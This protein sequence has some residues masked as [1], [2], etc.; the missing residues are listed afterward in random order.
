M[1]IAI[2][3]DD[4]DLLR[5]L[6]TVLGRDGG[7]VF[8][9]P[10][11]E[12]ALLMLR[13][14]LPLDVLIVDYQLGAF[15]AGWLLDRVRDSLPEGCRVILISGVS[16]LAERLDLRKMGVETFLPKPLDLRLLREK[17]AG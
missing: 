12:W 14:R 4:R 7:K 17:V 3:E 15:H 11:A 16:G 9:F 13:Q 2:V 1:R 8:A 5:T 6:E 10:S